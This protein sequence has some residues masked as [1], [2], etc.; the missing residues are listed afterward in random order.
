MFPEFVTF[1]Y[2]FMSCNSNNSPGME[3]KYTEVSTEWSGMN[4]MSRNEHARAS[5]VKMSRIISALS[6]I[7]GTGNV[8]DY[9][10]IVQD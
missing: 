10:R 8:Q 4:K 5:N 3:Q 7:T 6:R 1:I 9:G 2:V